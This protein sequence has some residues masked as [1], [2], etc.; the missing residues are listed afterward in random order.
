MK[1]IAILTCLKVSEICTG[2]GCMRAFN[3]GTGAFADYEEP[4]SLVAYLHCNGCGKD[5]ARDADLL[6]K[7]ERLEAIGTEAVH[8]GVCTKEKGEECA[9][10]AAILS[11]LED[12]GIRAVRGTHA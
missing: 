8:A 11:M 1:K 2:A 10:V 5:P 4:L 9:T 7:L 3:E 12:R 6:K